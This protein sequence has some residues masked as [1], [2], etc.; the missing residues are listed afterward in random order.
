MKQILKP[1][2]ILSCIIV[3]LL[4]ISISKTKCINSLEQQMEDGIYLMHE[5]EQIDS[6]YLEIMALGAELDSLKLKNE[7]Q[8]HFIEQL[9]NNQ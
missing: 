6:L 9:W 3:L 5:Y 8:E 1:I 7:N 4:L 2:P